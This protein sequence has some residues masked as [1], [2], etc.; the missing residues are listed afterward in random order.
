MRLFE[1]LLRLRPIV[2]LVAVALL[3]HSA[4]PVAEGGFEKLVVYDYVLWLTTVLVCLSVY[5]DVRLLGERFSYA[6]T[7]LLGALGAAG[8]VLGRAAS[9]ILNQAAC[10][11]LKLIPLFGSSYS[12]ESFAISLALSLCGSALAG[13]AL[14][15]HSIAGRAIVIFDGPPMTRAARAFTGLLAETWRRACDRFY[16]LLAFLFGF[17]F[18][19]LPELGW[20]PWLIGWD[21]VEYA[22]HLM[23]FLEKL[24]PFASYYWMGVMR[25][26]PPLLNVLLLL[27]AAAIGAWNTFKLY[28]SVAYGLL[29]LSSALVATRVFNLSKSRALLASATTALFII[30]LR[31]SW[32]YQ[33]QLLGSIFM[34]LSIA[35]LDSRGQLDTKRVAVSAA[36][37]ACSALSHE[38]TAFFSIAVLTVLALKLLKAKNLGGLVVTTLTLMA[39]VGLETWYWQ[40]VHASSAY[41][42]AAL[43]GVVSHD[44]SVAS[45]VI[46]YLMAGFGLVLPLAILALLDE[47]SSTTFSKVG[48]LSLM[49]AGLSPLIAPYTSVV[50]W[51]RFLAG[52][53]PIASTLAGAWIGR[54]VKDVRFHAI[55]VLLLLVLALPYAYAYQGTARFVSALK[56]FPSG[57]APSPAGVRTLNDLKSL[58]DWFREQGVKSTII[59]EPQAAK[60]IH[61]AIRN[62]A[63]GDLVHIWVE[64]A[65]IDARLIKQVL[66]ELGVDRA[67]V[68]CM[69]YLKGS[70]DLEVYELR[71]GIYRVYMVEVVEE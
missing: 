3:L 19:F 41:F 8:V 28:P 12:R 13:I 48:L 17:A 59:A 24:D 70:D 16:L 69:V 32:D 62:P 60:W 56:E 27:P 7:L 51:Y 14:L 44:P 18:R 34:L 29:T 47:S 31:T 63:P 55:F 54:H 36:L 71:G 68:V 65:S 23:D 25:N 15:I 64:R 6:S 26:V 53:A 21:T 52:A 43:I 1:L 61:L 38:V 66:E 4:T 10:S 50:V 9:L 49:A 5:L 42:G 67:Y 39:S 37:L 2:P 11:P 35:V 40:S 30:N 20:W 22:A 58:S 46:G 57:L 45:D 33:R